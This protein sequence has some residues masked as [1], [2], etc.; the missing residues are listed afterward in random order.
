MRSAVLVWRSLWVAA[1]LGWVSCGAPAE[2]AESPVVVNVKA[3]A[4]PAA[5][6]EP[7]GDIAER[8]PALTLAGW[9]T[10]PHEIMH[11]C[12]APDWCTAEV[13]D[14]LFIEDHAEGIT[15]AIELVQANFHICEWR[16]LMVAR[17]DRHSWVFAETD[18]ELIL[19]LH[20][21]TL[22]VKSEGCRDYCG[23]RA[24]LEAEFSRS[25]RVDE[26]PPREP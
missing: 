11:V 8:R 26:R 24:Y 22:K 5:S 15:V 13:T 19:D 9:Y 3:G 20:G 1:V 7:S 23:A 17:P 21:D 12:D 25:S 16:G 10:T 14:G 4:A 2:R 18:C 6:G